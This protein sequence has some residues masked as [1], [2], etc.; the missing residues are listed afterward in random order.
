MESTN[1][2]MDSKPAAADEAP[3]AR[4]DSLAKL[5]EHAAYYA[6]EPDRSAANHAASTRAAMNMSAANLTRHRIQPIDFSASNGRIYANGAPFDISTSALFD[7]ALRIASR[8]C[9]LDILALCQHTLGQ[10]P[11]AMLHP[12]LSFVTLCHM[13]R[14]RQLVRE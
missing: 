4:S 1:H 5:M 12:P 13:C 8:D 9:V 10:C 14:G 6:P 11:C 3:T 2:I 7:R